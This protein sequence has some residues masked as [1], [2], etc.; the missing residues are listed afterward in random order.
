MKLYLL[1]VTYFVDGKVSN[2][3][4]SSQRAHLLADFLTALAFLARRELPDL[5]CRQKP[6]QP[7]IGTIATPRSDEST[8]HRHPTEEG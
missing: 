4:K 2:S 6:K 7:R 8:G 5:S 3:S 1:F